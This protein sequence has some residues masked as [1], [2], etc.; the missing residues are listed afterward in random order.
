MAFIFGGLLIG[1]GV[2]GG[3]LQVKELKLPKLAGFARIASIIIG[4]AF[5]A[6]AV[7][8]N[9]KLP[10]IDVDHPSQSTKTFQKPTYDGERLDACFEWA[11]Q[12]GEEAATAWCK[13][14]GFIRA[15]DY[16]YEKVGERGIK[17]KLIGTQQ[18]C[19]EKMCA[20]FSSITCEK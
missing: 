10:P 7:S 1:A 19:D 14:Q 12:C 17:T 8:L 11:K 3:G 4:I 18:V 5:I 15:I 13:T 16:P 2:F 20:S 6:L 9:L